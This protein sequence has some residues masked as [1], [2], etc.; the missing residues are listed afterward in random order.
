MPYIST[1]S[2]RRISGNVIAVSMA[3]TTRAPPTEPTNPP[4]FSHVERAGL[5]PVLPVLPFPK[6]NAAAP[7]LP[8]TTAPIPSSHRPNQTSPRAAP[9]PPTS[10]PAILP[11]STEPVVSPRAPPPSRPEN[12]SPHPPQ[13]PAGRRSS[14]CTAGR[15]RQLAPIPADVL[16]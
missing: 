10:T 8:R 14:Q 2:R 13:N 11:A 1:P 16:R 5:T 6:K 7:Q 4:Y 15:M 12:P 3:P 9:R